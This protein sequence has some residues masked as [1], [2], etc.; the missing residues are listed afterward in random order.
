MI[1]FYEEMFICMNIKHNNMSKKILVVEDE[2][3]LLDFYDKMLTAEDYTVYKSETGKKAIDIFDK[4]DPKIIIMDIKLPDI[5]GIEV[6]RYIKEKSPD[7]IIIA[8]SAYGERLKDAV[9][10]GAYTLVQKPFLQKEL[11][12]LIKDLTQSSETIKDEAID[13]SFTKKKVP[14]SLTRVAFDAVITDM[15]EGSLRILLKKT[16][17]DRYIGNLPPHDDSPSITVDEYIILIQNIFDI[18][19]QKYEV[20]SDNTFTNLIDVTEA[21]P[22]LGT[23]VFSAIRIADYY[24]KTQQQNVTA[25]ENDVK[26]KVKS[27]YYGVLLSKSIVDVNKLTQQNAEENYIAVEKKYR[28][29]VATEFDFLRSK[30]RLDNS[31]PELSKSERNYEISRKILLNELGLKDQQDINVL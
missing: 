18:F 14:S 8:V 31:V 25:T 19:G 15:G 11:I 22:V 6:T 12:S 24:S 30:V 10:A 17:V 28:L 3:E 20:G 13:V 2:I 1:F 29:G 26:K 23:P 7:A 5:S 16:N 21:L 27:A 4:E 9:N